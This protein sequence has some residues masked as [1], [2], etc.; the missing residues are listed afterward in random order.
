MADTRKRTIEGVFG[1]PGEPGSYGT[2]LIERQLLTLTLSDSRPVAGLS[3]AN[4]FSPRSSEYSDAAA[5]CVTQSARQCTEL[6]RASC[7]PV[8]TD[9]E[10]W[11]ADQSGF[12]FRAKKARK[13]R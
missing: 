10:R 5:R 7:A 6:V 3:T 2:L 8:T 11:P 1:R 12:G 9:Y 4:S 13:P